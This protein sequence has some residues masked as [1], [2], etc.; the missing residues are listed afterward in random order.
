M[1][2]SVHKPR[3]SPTLWWLKTLV[4]VRLTTTKAISTWGT[5]AVAATLIQC[6]NLS[7]QRCKHL[8]FVQ[9]DSMD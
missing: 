8:K 4:V 6:A 7:P 5:K 3:E 2:S 9:V 1:C